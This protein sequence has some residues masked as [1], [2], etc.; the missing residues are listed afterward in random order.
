MDTSLS[1]LVL[2]SQESLCRGGQR[3]ELLKSGTM[4]GDCKGQLHPPCG[5]I[6]R[7]GSGPKMHLHLSSAT[8][9]L[10]R[11]VNSHLS[12]PVASSVRGD[13]WLRSNESPCNTG[14][15]KAV[16]AVS[17][18]GSGRYPEEGVATHC[19]ILAWKILWTEEPGRLQSVG[20]QESDTT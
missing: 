1:P 15:C 6:P 19:S 8:E 5:G 12:P 14:T 2:P 18:L 16:D 11:K 10:P 13:G 4:D 3:G 17:I 9:S 20:S 7:V